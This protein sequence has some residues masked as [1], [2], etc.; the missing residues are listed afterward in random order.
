MVII[1]DLNKQLSSFTDRVTLHGYRYLLRDTFIFQVRVSLTN[2]Y[3]AL[4]QLVLQHEPL[5]KLLVGLDQWGGLTT[6]MS[7]GAQ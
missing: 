2:V 3:K 1:N 4:R 5:L 6:Q 7:C